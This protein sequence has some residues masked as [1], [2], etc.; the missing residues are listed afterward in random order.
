M[1]FPF[2]QF[3]TC[4]LTYSWLIGLTQKQANSWYFGSYLGID[5]NLS[6]PQLLLDGKITFDYSAGAES[7]S[8]ISD[9]LGNLLFYTDGVTVWDRLHNMMPN[10]AGLWGT[11]TTTQTLIVPNAGNKNIYYIFTAS[12]QGDYDNLFPLDRKGFRY[13]EVDL[14]LNSGLGE[15]VQKNILLSTS[16]TEKIAGTLHANGKD[17]WVAMHEWNSNTFRLYLVTSNGISQPMSFKTGSLHA[18]PDQYGGNAIG[19]MKF[20]P[21]GEKLALAIYKDGVIEVFDFDAST[22]EIKFSQRTNIEDRLYGIE[23]SPSG[24]FLYSTNGIHSVY[25]FDLLAPNISTSLFRVAYDIPYDSPYGL[26]LAS[27]GKIYIAKYDMYFLSAI[28]YPDSSREACSYEKEAIKFP[29]DGVRYCKNG[30]PNFISTYFYKPEL[31][32]PKPYFEMPNVFTPNGDGFNEHF[33]PLKK[34]NVDTYLMKIFNRWGQNIFQTNNMI[35]GWDGG[36]HPAG[37]YYW[38]AIIIGINGK[39]Y[40]QKDFVQLIR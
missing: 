8:V 38:Q 25:Q 21:N 19:Q 13:S 36:D 6:P 14:S 5:F 12:P 31:Y 28:N 15:V 33:I 30:L 7:A 23:F 11:S 34:Y 35:K 32:P 2:R 29:N 10:G 22:G 3:L 1:K 37:V 18:G 9:S 24:R 4:L 16:T 39:E 17:I 27:N 20:S 40:S 26:Q